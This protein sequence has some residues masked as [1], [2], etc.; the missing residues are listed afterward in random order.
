MS[1]AQS[2]GQAGAIGNRSRARSWTRAVTRPAWSTV[3]ALGVYLAYA[4]H[5]TWPVILHLG[6]QVYGAPGDLTGSIAMLREM[7]HEHRF[8][9]VPGTLHDFNAPEGLPID[10]RF[11]LS[12]W[13]LLGA[14]WLIGLV[15]GATAAYS[16]VTLFGYVASGMAMF[17]LVRK[18]TRNAWAAL[19]V[20]WAFAFYP[21]AELN[22]QGHNAHVH[23]WVFV[24]IVWRGLALHEKPTVRNAVWLG[25]ASVLAM[26][27]NPY[28]ILFGAVVLATF[29]VWELGYA[30]V[31]GRDRQRIKVVLIAG[32]IGAGYA[33]VL[34]ALTL[35]SN[36]ASGN[37]PLRTH[38]PEELTVYS[39]RAAE[40]VVPPAGNLIVGG[41]TR[42]YV[43]THLHG[44]NWS[45][46]TLYIGISTILFALAGL[47]LGLRRKGE[48]RQRYQLG[49]FAA[50]AVVAFVFSA[51]PHVGLGP[52]TVPT[53][54]ELISHVTS[55]WRA[56]SRFVIVVM[57]GACLLAGMGLA[58]LAESLGRVGGIALLAVATVIVPLDLINRQEPKPVSVLA[59]QPVYKVLEAQPRG[60]VAQ[61]PLYPSGT[62]KYGDIFFQG[63]H[64]M[65]VLNGYV[66]TAQEARDQ[67]LQDLSDPETV[68]KLATL[69]VK[70]IVATTEPVEPPVVAAGKPPAK[71]VVKLGEG[72]YGGASG[73][74][75]KIIAKPKP[76]VTGGGGFGPVE[77]P[78]RT[79]AVQWLTGEQGS[80]DVRAACGS[81]TGTVRFGLQTLLHPR[82]FTV[83]DGS[84]R[85]VLRRTVAP[86]GGVKVSAP[87]A[88]RKGAGRLTITVQ[89]GVEAIPGPDPRSASVL[90]INPRVKVPAR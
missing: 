47:I 66:G 61:Y 57:M 70:Y 8:P 45:E 55:T 62:G 17:L 21:F 87:I 52:I 54:S 90:L 40:Y 24:L 48:R 16:L 78:A 39:A 42:H 32:V 10:W 86:G 83:R 44:S 58:Y 81:C 85:V 14:L 69:G 35:S 15:V 79:Q 51:P 63:Y 29:G 27:S 36:G 43:E 19:I 5:L 28:F 41:H 59:D 67:A 22:G 89:P 75:Y 1:A 72:K 74:V 73:V 12:Q 2:L 77:T 71:D 53:P 25:L 30:W 64:D 68:P 49:L 56:Y 65:P 50:I 46:N 4:L 33:L 84:G 18:V 31:N 37:T 26:A 3:L 9:F 23:G 76:I 34:A 38:S 60:I 6:D 82:T 88:V 7:L 13:P 20:G 80:V 11:N